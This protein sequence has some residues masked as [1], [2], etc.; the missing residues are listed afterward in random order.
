MDQRV[1]LSVLLAAGLL[2]LSLAPVSQAEDLV[3]DTLSDDVD[4]EDELDLDVAGVD[5][6]EEELDGDM[7]NEGPPAPKTPPTPKVSS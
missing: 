3:E 1:W 7:Q 5:D 4:V 2:C 6:E